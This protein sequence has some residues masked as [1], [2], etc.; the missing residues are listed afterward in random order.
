[1]VYQCW[2]ESSDDTVLTGTLNLN[3]ILIKVSDNY[4][5]GT[6]QLV[7]SD[8]TSAKFT[9]GEPGSSWRCTFS[10]RPL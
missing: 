9:Y 8:Y 10:S 7:T 6:W 3:W 1:M 5:H 2:P 4:E